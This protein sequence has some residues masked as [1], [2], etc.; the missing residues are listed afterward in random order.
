MLSIHS[1]CVINNLINRRAPCIFIRLQQGCN[2]NRN[3]FMYTLLQPKKKQSNTPLPPS[4]IPIYPPLYLAYLGKVLA[5]LSA[6]GNDVL[7]S[8]IG[9]K[10]RF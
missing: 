7:I 6:S 9:S 3:V 2:N 8:R 4:N 10:N 1:H 5:T